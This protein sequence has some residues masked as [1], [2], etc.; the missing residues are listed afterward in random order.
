MA[1]TAFQNQYRQEFVKGFERRR[2]LLRDSVTTEVEVKGNAA[3]FLVADS[4]GAAAITRGTNGRIPGRP[5]N[6]NQYTATLVEWHDKPERTGF[7]IFASQGDGRRIMQET[8]QAVLNRRIDQDIISELA[9]ATNAVGVAAATATL[10]MVRRA[11]TIL[12]VNNVPSDGQIYAAVTPAFINNLMAVKEFASAQYVNQQPLVSADPDWK[13]APGYYKWLGVNWLEHPGLTGV[14]TSNET[15]Y[16][17]HKTAIGHAAPSDL[18]KTYAGYN[19]EHDYS[20][21]HAFAY[22][23]PKLLQNSGVV[24]MRHDGSSL[25]A[26]A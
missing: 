3:V 24:I 4:G 8:A 6:L 26:T 18:I 17:Y 15:C 7:N 9:N 19:E 25:V 10:T 16:M 23:G 21:V 14:G 5:D 13:D 20:F 11:K 12:G 1:D 22:M 2:S